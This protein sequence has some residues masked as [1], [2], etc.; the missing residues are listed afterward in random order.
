MFCSPFNGGSPMT[1]V[2]DFGAVG[3]GQANAP[4]AVRYALNNGESFADFGFGIDRLSRTIEANLDRISFRRP[5]LRRILAALILGLANHSEV[6]GRVF[7]ADTASSAPVPNIVLIVADDL[8]YG[9]LGCYG[10]RRA[11]TPHLDRLAQEGL[12]L[13]DFHANAASCSPTRAALLTGRYQQ[14]SGV[15]EAL[16]ERS[17]GLPDEARTIAEYLKP[18]GYRTGI[19]GKWHLGSRPDSPALPN[20]QG[21][22]VFRGARHGGIDYVSHVDRY[23]RLDWWHD[24]QSVDETGYATDLLTEHAVRFIED[25]R[26]EPFFLYLPHLAVHFPWMEPATPS[27]RKV[28]ENYDNQLKTGPH[29]PEEVPGVVDR[30]VERLDDG[31]GRVMD[32]LRRLKL[33]HNTLV[34]FTSDNGGYVNYGGARNVSSNGPLRGGKI[35]VYEG[36]HRVPCIAWWP[37]RIAAGGVNDATLM[38]MDLLPTFLELARVAPPPADAPQAL[39]GVSLV[40]V[41]LRGEPLA[42]RTLFWQTGDMKAVRRGSWKV[43]IQHDQPPEL[44]DLANDLGE[45]KNLAKQEPEK[46]RDLLA[47]FAEWQSQFAK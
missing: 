7:A 4:A 32:C 3:D 37:G 47:A 35:A 41:L 13:T 28:G 33:D 20:R 24:D 38:T 40:P 36:G 19:F 2:R 6:V 34:I 25:R 21:F 12:R 39:D 17:P 42:D 10:G 29:A 31:V 27:Y 11:R 5:F 30:M 43:V 16:S 15:V 8:G 45:R 9:D 1:S 22:D 23:G 44:Y 46:L 18:A 14:R 26:D